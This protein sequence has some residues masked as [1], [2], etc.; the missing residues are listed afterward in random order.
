MAFAV[1][2]GGNF[3]GQVTPGGNGLRVRC[4]RLHRVGLDEMYAGRGYMPRAVAMVADYAFF[5]LGLHRIEINIRPENAAS[6]RVVEKLV[7]AMKG[8]WRRYLHIA[9]DRRD[10]STYALRRGSTG[11]CPDCRQ[12]TVKESALEQSFRRFC[13]QHAVSR[14]RRKPWWHRFRA[15]P[16]GLLYL[17][18][19]VLWAAVLIPDGCD[20][21]NAPL[22]IA[23]P[24]ASGTRWPPRSFPAGSTAPPT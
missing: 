12:G 21:M 14:Q 4:A 2:V 6:I 19:L 16:N 1:L 3:A 7:S 8:F 22:S 10:H 20:A 18:I 5:T 11:R 23:P 24:A 9:G 13:K 17:A 15:M